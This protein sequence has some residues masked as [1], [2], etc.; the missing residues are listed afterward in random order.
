MYEIR[1]ITN[2][3]ERGLDYFEPSFPYTFENSSIAELQD[4]SASWSYTINI[5]RTANNDEIFEAAGMPFVRTNMPYKRLFCNVYADGVQI[6][7]R[8]VMFI[9]STTESE[10]EV[11]IVSGNA[12]VFELMSDID[13]KNWTNETIVKL[14][15]N[16]LVVPQD[17][18]YSY[19]P[20]LHID[21]GYT[22]EQGTQVFLQNQSLRNDLYWYAMPMLQVGGQSG[23]LTRILADIGYQFVT[24]TPAETLDSLW[25]NVISRDKKYERENVEAKVTSYYDKIPPVTAIQAVNSSVRDHEDYEY[26][27]HTRTTIP[28]NYYTDIDGNYIDGQT[29]LRAYLQSVGQAVN[30]INIRTFNLRSTTIPP[31][32]EQVPDTLIHID[33]TNYRQFFTDGVCDI[34]V[35]IPWDIAIGD[36]TWAYNLGVF[37]DIKVEDMPWELGGKTYNEKIVTYKHAWLETRAKSTETGGKDYAVPMESISLEANIGYDSAFDFFKMLAQVFG[38]IVSVKDGTIYAHT[39]DYIIGRKNVAID[40]SDK[41]LRSNDTQVDFVFGD[42]AQKNTIKTNENEAED[43]ATPEYTYT[44]PNEVLDKQRDILEV[45]IMPEKV[46]MAASWKRD[47]EGTYEFEGGKQQLMY[48]PIGQWYSH[49]ANTIARAYA[50]LFDVLQ[51]VQVVT[52]KMLLTAMDIQTFDPYTP[53]FLQPLGGYYYVN[54]ISDWE[55]GKACNVELLRL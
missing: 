17:S 52:A 55:D 22:N 21:R 29:A 26:F 37:A 40:W 45:D 34:E 10:Y 38:W 24:D 43:Y 50:S 53:I 14:P 9:D 23:L 20:T 27:L 11:Q 49:N 15:T 2:N 12:D 31:Y 51:A 46:Q 47:D 1:V 16:S 39:F 6:I 7:K 35:P 33:T 48:N 19:P 42:Y 28:N 54:K 18:G 41:L 25:L 30:Y 8:G 13:L 36:E 3:G 4:Q 32:T 44:I 5:P